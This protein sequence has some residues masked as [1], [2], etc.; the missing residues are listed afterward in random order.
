MD[1]VC[2]FNLIEQQMYEL[3]RFQQ[4]IWQP[5]RDAHYLGNN[6]PNTNSE[7]IESNDHDSLTYNLVTYSPTIKFDANENHKIYGR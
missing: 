7:P 1:F 6:L 2:Y 4:Q 3:Q 5:W